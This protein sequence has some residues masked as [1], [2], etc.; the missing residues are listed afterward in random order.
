[1][2]KSGEVKLLINDN[3]EGSGKVNPI[4]VMPL[5]GL[6]VGSD[7]GGTVGEYLPDYPL[8]AQVNLTLKLLPNENKK[9]RLGPKNNAFHPLKMTPIYQEF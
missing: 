4:T 3:L 6:S 5:D 7:P 2:S 9:T 8:N 1:M